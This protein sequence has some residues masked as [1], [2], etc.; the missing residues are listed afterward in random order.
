MKNLKYSLG[1]I[2]KCVSTILKRGVGKKKTVT[3][4]LKT[5]LIWATTRFTLLSSNIHGLEWLKRLSNRFNPKS[6]LVNELIIEEINNNVGK[7]LKVEPKDKKYSKN[8][9]IYFHGGGFVTGSPYAII[10]FISRLAMSS[11][12]KIIIPFYPT[13]PEKFYPSAHKFAIEISEFIL[14]EIETPIYLTGDSAGANLAI[15]TFK[16]LTIN[17]R[18]KIRGCILISPWVE[19][20][21][22]K[23]TIQSN[24]KND[25]ANSQYLKN[26][27]DMYINNNNELDEY[28][29]TLN[30]SQLI[31]LPKTIITVGTFEMLLD[32]VKKLDDN[33]K[34]LKTE[35]TLIEYDNMF[36]TFWN[37]PAKIREADKLIDDIASWLDSN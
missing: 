29:L 24:S 14:K 5:E 33:L 30:K 11:N 9:I 37:V 32:Q 21:S 2:E 25:V 19:P 13:A 4:N 1:L 36:H 31:K 20:T 28:P 27:Y 34:S 10:E 23:G 17:N 35:T 22:T 7:Y 6:S 8:I 26:C 3:W 18:Q 15:T 16:K 12:S